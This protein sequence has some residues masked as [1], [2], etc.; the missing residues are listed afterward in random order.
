MTQDSTPFR[1]E[2]F[3]PLL[4]KKKKKK[5]LELAVI[6]NAIHSRGYGLSAR[7]K[8]FLQALQRTN[9]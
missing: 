3:F 5:K 9:T 4:Q 7:T 2:P 8:S 6:D 1:D